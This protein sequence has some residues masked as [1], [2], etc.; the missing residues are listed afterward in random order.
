MS[1]A[2]S[3]KHEGPH[4]TGVLPRRLTEAE[5]DRAPALASLDA[6][7]IEDLGDEEYHRFLEAL[8]VE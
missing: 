5:F 6:L 4:G 3:S 1:D 2:A 8:G 7:V